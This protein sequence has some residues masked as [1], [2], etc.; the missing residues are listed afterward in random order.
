M[1]VL[2]PLIAVTYEWQKIV[3]GTDTFL[4][5]VSHGFLFVAWLVLMGPGLLGLAVFGAVAGAVS[6]FRFRDRVISLER[7]TITCALIADVIVGVSGT[8]LTW[9]IRS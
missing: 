8:A 7:R 3:N 2:G 5:V 6:F 4:D 9:L 1:F